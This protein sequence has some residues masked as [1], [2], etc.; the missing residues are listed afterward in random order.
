MTVVAVLACSVLPVCPRVA[1]VMIASIMVAKAPAP[2][3]WMAAKAGTAVV[4]ML[5]ASSASPI[6]IQT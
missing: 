5:A 3:A 4:R 1:R 6:G 2:K